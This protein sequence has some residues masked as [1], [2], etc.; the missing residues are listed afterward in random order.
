MLAIRIENRLHY[1][2]NIVQLEIFL[3]QILRLLT[4]YV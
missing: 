2:N 1:I 3:A 4:G